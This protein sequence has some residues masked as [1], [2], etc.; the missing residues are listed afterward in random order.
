MTGVPREEAVFSTLSGRRGTKRPVSCL[1][2]GLSSRRS[3]SV[4]ICVSEL[5]RHS[6]ESR[7]NGHT[8]L[9]VKTCEGETRKPL[10]ARPV[11]ERPP[12]QLCVAGAPCRVQQPEASGGRPPLSQRPLVS[13][14]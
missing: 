11:A 10:G 2:C 4:I 3:Y 13:L 9:N 1:C 7:K 6:S 12:P 8:A 14:Y 5:F